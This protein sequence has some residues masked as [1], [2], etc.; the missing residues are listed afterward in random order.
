MQLS[1]QSYMPTGAYGSKA[2][3]PVVHV[4]QKLSQR[5]N[6]GHMVSQVL[7]HPRNLLAYF[8]GFTSQYASLLSPLES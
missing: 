5:S 6:L 4:I 1:L 7:I 3:S 8:T 2:W